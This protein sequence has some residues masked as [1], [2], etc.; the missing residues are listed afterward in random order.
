MELLLL[1]IKSC[2][3]VK[4]MV[5]LNNINISHPLSS[6]DI[7]SAPYCHLRIFHNSPHLPTPRPT[8]PPKK[9][10]KKFAWAL[11]SISLGT[12]VIILRRNEKQRLC[13]ILG[14]LV[15]ARKRSHHW[16]VSLT[17]NNTKTIGRMTCLCFLRPIRRDLTSSSYSKHIRGK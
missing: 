4:Q 5:V 12:A 1:L 16:C 17:P 13:K 9:K 8:P 10:K 3:S 15:A 14:H 6:F 11:F 2:S 7:T